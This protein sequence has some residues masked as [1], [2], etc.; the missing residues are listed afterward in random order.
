[1]KSNQIRKDMSEQKCTKV[2]FFVLIAMMFS[3]IIGMLLPIV[4]VKYRLTGVG[5]DYL[6]WIENSLVVLF[7]VFV[8]GAV[9][10]RISHPRKI[11]TQTPEKTQHALIIAPHG[12]NWE[13]L[14][15]DLPIT[16]SCRLYSVSDLSLLENISSDVVIYNIGGNWTRNVTRVLAHLKKVS[17]RVILILPNKEVRR[18]LPGHDFE[19]IIKP[20]EINGLK[21]KLT[22]LLS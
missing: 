1:M 13:Y 14:L 10:Y 20:A 16:V 12:W 22:R 15:S 3:V 7:V 8:V 9:I 4:I 5:L 18:K 17:K 21:K 11:V 19:Y 6:R 2:C